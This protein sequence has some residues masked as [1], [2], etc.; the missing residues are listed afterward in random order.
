M[1]KMILSAVL[2]GSTLL[3]ATTNKDIKLEAKTAL[4]KMG[5]AL[6]SNMKKNMKQGGALQAAK[7]CSKEAVNIEKK[8][9]S[10]YKKGISV[11]RVSLKLR[12]PNNKPS[13]DELLVLKNIQNDVDAHKTIPKMTVKKIS[14]KEYKVY[15]PIFIKKNICLSCHGIEKA[16]HKEAYKVIKE[17]YPKDKAIDYKLNDFRGAFVIEIK[18]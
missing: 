9:N 4:M 3:N 14:K 8:I 15:K 5:G 17:K 6:K 2:L 11:K 1:T 12:N 16:R 10:N 18:K 13:A 7:F